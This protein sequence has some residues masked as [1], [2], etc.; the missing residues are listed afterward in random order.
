M[1]LQQLTEDTASGVG[2]T[3]EL[4]PWTPTQDEVD[5]ARESTIQQA[6]RSFVASLKPKE[7]TPPDPTTTR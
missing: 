4:P 1:L 5:V 6:Q 7:N 2:P 3:A